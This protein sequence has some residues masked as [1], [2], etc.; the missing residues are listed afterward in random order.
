MKTIAIIPVRAGSKRVPGKNVRPFAGKSLNIIAC[1]QAVRLQNL[2]EDIVLT[3]DSDEAINQGE[4]CGITSIRRRPNELCTDSA[5]SEDAID[6]AIKWTGKSYSHV[7][8]LEPTSP[9]RLD[10]DITKS[11]E[12]A[13]NGMGVKSVVLVKNCIEEEIINDRYQLEGS[14]HLWR[15]DSLYDTPYD[16]FNLLEIPAERAWHIDYP[17]QFKVAEMLYKGWE[18]KYILSGDYSQYRHYL[19]KNGLTECE[20]R[21]MGHPEGWCSVRPDNLI[22]V[23]DWWKSEAM[24]VDHI[25]ADIF[26]LTTE[27][28][29]NGIEEKT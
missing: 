29:R 13:K 7:L 17:W 15:T 3:T 2:F 26:R 20:A 14:I 28:E 10:S 8:L 16:R 24:N 22:L 19:K 23:G 9:L 4:K 5:L 18:M 12:L 11:L 21:W 27:E 25:R 1:E 6:D